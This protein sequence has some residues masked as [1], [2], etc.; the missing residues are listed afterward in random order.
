MHDMS[1]RVA[2]ITGAAGNLG[3]AVARLFRRAGART[4][5]AARSADRLRQ[6]F[7]E[8][9][10]SPDHL[11]AAVDLTDPAATA[12]MIDAAKARFGRLDV[13]VTT[14][15]GFRGGKPV[16][17][18]A[19][20]TW[21]AMFAVNLRTT[22]LPCRAVVPHFLAQGSGR[23]VTVGAGAALHG[24]AGL[25]AYNA[26]KSA[27]LSL[28]QTLAAELKPAGIT[29]NCVL[30][31]IIDTPENRA[32]MPEADRNTWVAPKAIAEVILFL[33]SDAARAVTGA[34]LPVFGM[35]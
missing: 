30:P 1:D 9:A 34:V 29:A 21:D 35:G 3:T 13:L 27:V 22:L 8:G 16:Q 26:A 19:L 15:G 17:A 14:T 5:L 20:E 32:A 10:D 33:A 12:A 4:V 2:I 6:L 11:L 25:A 31:G 18:E 28:T 23:I 24:V 7:P